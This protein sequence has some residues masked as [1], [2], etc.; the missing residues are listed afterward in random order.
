MAAM[1]GARVVLARRDRRRVGSRSFPS[2]R[3]EEGREPQKAWSLLR[4]DA[5]EAPAMNQHIAARSHH[6]HDIIYPSAI[7]FLL[8]HVACFAAFWTGISERAVWL[9]VGLYWLRMF[10]VTAGYHRYFSHRAFATSRAFQFVLALLAQSTFQKS[11]LWWAAKHRHHHLH[12]DMPDDVH[13]P[14]HTGF[15]YSHFGW[16]FATKHDHADLGT[17]PD[18]AKYPELRWLHRHET[19]PGILL[20][21]LCWAIAGWSGLVVGFLWSTVLV[22]HA[23]FCI[24]SLAHVRGT[25]RYVTGDDS[26][27]NPILAFATMGEGWHNNHHAFQSSVR[28]GFRWWEIDLTFYLLR[29]LAMVRIVRDLKAP[30][31][32][33]LRNEQRLGTK[34][35]HRSAARLAERYNP[36]RIAHSLRSML[37]DYELAMLLETLD[38]ASDRV[39]QRW[40]EATA[41]MPSRADLLTEARAVFAKTPSLEE[42]VDR[43]HQLVLAAVGKQLGATVPAS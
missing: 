30:P 27:N 21:L 24:N 37:P 7:P 43:A 36:E 6:D 31:E 41:H 34:V 28:Q 17:V 18:L 16:I 39:A 4:Q 42:I 15:L 10:G 8:V 3:R 12:S 2:A 14:R 9:C 26:R 35:I 38:H 29:L 20:G 32:S 1:R 19:A 11:I 33:V 25:Q 5:L 40:S 13:S 23:T 22:Y